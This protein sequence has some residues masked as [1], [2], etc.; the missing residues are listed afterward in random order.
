MLMKFYDPVFTLYFK[1]IL[2]KAWLPW[3]NTKN[4][5][6]SSGQILVFDG[7][8]YFIVLFSK[9]KQYMQNKKKKKRCEFFCIF[10][11]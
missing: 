10:T 2:N 7:F 3:K 6:W 9:I 5:K 4:W 8:V 11:V 1:I